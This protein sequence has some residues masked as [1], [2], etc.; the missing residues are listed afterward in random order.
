MLGGAVGGGGEEVFGFG[1]MVLRRSGEEVEVGLLLRVD[2]SGVGRGVELD[3]GLL[4]D[5]TVVGMMAGV[6]AKAEVGSVVIGSG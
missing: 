4:V 5:G 1:E 6:V 3:A 2:G